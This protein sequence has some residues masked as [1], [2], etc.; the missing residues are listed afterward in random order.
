MYIYIYVYIL[1]KLHIYIYI[2]IYIYIYICVYVS[3]SS[4]VQLVYQ[5]APNQIMMIIAPETV[6]EPLQPQVLHLTLN[7]KP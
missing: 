2:F 3:I 6:Q 4:I 7:P 5:T 1:D